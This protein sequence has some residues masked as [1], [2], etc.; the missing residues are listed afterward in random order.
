MFVSFGPAGRAG[1]LKACPAAYRLAYP[2]AMNRLCC[3]DNL[4]V[5]KDTSAF[6]DTCVDLIYL[7]PPFNSNRDYN[8]LFKSPVGRRSSSSRRDLCRRLSLTGIRRPAFILSCCRN[9]SEKSPV[10]GTVCSGKA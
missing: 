7:A 4:T 3:G 8:L 9:D 2:A 1:L 5:L 6:P 10:H